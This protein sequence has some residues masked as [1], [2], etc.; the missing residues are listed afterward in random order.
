MTEFGMGLTNPLRGERIPGAVGTP[1]PQVEVCI[2][3][4][5]VGS[6]VGYDIIAQG[7]ASKTNVTP[8][9]HTVVGDQHSPY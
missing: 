1:F 5:L 6:K 7:T 4:P 3:K 8:G 9:M 2:V